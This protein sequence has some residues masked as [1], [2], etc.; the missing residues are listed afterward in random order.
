MWNMSSS[1]RHGDGGSA[2]CFTGTLMDDVSRHDLGRHPALRVNG[3]HVS[4]LKVNISIC[5]WYC[6]R[7]VHRRLN[8]TDS[9][10]QM[11]CSEMFWEEVSGLK[12][13]ILF[14]PVQQTESRSSD[15][16][17]ISNL[18]WSEL[19]RRWTINSSSL[20]WTFPSRQKR[21]LHV[22]R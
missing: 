19:N 9:K 13:F 16:L 7:Q 10:S 11:R 18:T 17:Y 12:H 4:V 14:S 20:C 2:G 3:L 1:Q 5:S 6:H 21:L 8:V 15:L 22:Y